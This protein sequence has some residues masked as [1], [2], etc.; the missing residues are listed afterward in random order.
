MNWASIPK[1][2]KAI[3][4][5]IAAHCD[6]KGES[7]PSERTLAILSGRSDKTVREG[8]QGLIGFPGFSVENYITKRGRRA[9][10]FIMTFPP[11]REEG[12]SFF[13]Y[14]YLIEGGNWRLLKP[15]SQALYPVMRYFAY[16]DE[17]VYLA[18]EE[19]AEDEYDPME[20]KEFYKARKW[21][22]C[23]AETTIL[24][25]YSHITRPSVYE[26]LRDLGKYFLVEK[27][28]K[29]DEGVDQWKVFIRPPTYYKR[30]FL[31]M[32]VARTYGTEK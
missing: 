32:E 10:R 6:D 22:C 30:D 4:P 18:N 3:L 20:F 12:R 28:G 21:E 8:I 31:N 23:E 17:E 16:F 1:S 2:S 26:A 7:F 9:K 19:G 5:V 13:F 25:K 11:E 15:V 29:S 14:K 24:A 27:M